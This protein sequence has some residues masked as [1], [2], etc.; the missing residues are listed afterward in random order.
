MSGIV[1]ISCID[2]PAAPGVSWPCYKWGIKERERERIWQDVMPKKK[3][4]EKE[5]NQTTITTT[6]N[7]KTKLSRRPL[8]KWICTH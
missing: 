5:N 3:K 1:R 8:R 2:T 6:K 4:K 7:P